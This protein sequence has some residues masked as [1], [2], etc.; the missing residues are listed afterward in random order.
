MEQQ[1]FSS[2]W[3][4][5][6][7]EWRRAKVSLIPGTSGWEAPGSPWSRQG[8]SGLLSVFAVSA[9]HPDTLAPN[10]CS[11]SRRKRRSNGCH[12]G[13]E[14]RGRIPTPPRG[15]GGQQNKH[16]PRHTRGGRGRRTQEAAGPRRR[17]RETLAEGA[18]GPRPQRRERTE[19]EAA[20][21]PSEQEG[22]K[23]AQRKRET[24]QGISRTTC[25]FQGGS[26]YRNAPYSPT[27]ALPALHA[28]RAGPVMPITFKITP[29]FH[30]HFY[31]T[32]TV[33]VNNWR[34]IH[35]NATSFTPDQV[36]TAAL[37]R[38]SLHR[39]TV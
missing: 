1:D 34:K 14:G 22:E 2:D 9:G 27:G 39:F 35:K 15:G 32:Y 38:R 10:C 18:A 25:G 4:A 7:A 5:E 8:A 21:R 20:S 13:K 12:R 31:L 23:A 3:G 17:R 26:R 36:P 6:T 33:H 37:K 30:D 24:G 11:E 29:F 16:E 19:M 28:S